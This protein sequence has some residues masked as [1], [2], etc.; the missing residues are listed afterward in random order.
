MTFNS[1]LERMTANVANGSLNAMPTATTAPVVN[2]M[3]RDGASIKT[4]VKASSV[5]LSSPAPQHESKK[6]S[7]K[8][9]TRPEDY[10]KLFTILD[11][12]KSNTISIEEFRAYA[13]RTQGINSKAIRQLE[14]ILKT[15][16]DSYKEL[17]FAEFA[18]VCM[19]LDIS[20]EG[21]MW[22]AAAI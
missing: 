11:T 7:V 15:S 9:T 16:G 17:M 20:P 2:S 14:A 3:D 22:R 8:S 13:E 19:R 1:F 18:Q 6:K 5:Q 21:I 12:D 4:G 10:E